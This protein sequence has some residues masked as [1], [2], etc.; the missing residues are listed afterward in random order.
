MFPFFLID[1]FVFLLTLPVLP[2]SFLP[3]REI[4]VL[5]YADGSDPVGEKPI[6]GERWQRGKSSVLESEGLS[7]KRGQGSHSV[8]RKGGSCRQVSQ[9]EGKSL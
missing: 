2:S 7:P 8:R 3:S 9:Y 1:R 6:W 5:L 4:T